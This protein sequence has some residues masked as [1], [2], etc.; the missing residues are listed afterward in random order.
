MANHMIEVGN[1]VRKY[2]EVVAVDGIT[3][4]V[5]EGGF[6]GFLGPNGAG[7]TTTMR[8]LATLLRKTSGE[9][10]IA[11]F[12]VD[13]QP[14]EVRK[15]IGFAMQDVSLECLLEQLTQIGRTQSTVHPVKHG[16]H[17]ALDRSQAIAKFMR[18]VAYGLIANTDPT[19]EALLLV[20]TAQRFLAQSDRGQQA[21]N[22]HRNRQRVE[23]KPDVRKEDD[24]D[25]H[26]PAGEDHT[27][28]GAEDESELRAER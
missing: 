4:Q 9:V 23:G 19:S 21:K 5:G 28:A 20:F 22:D 3:F 6:F 13:A 26:C 7:K 8:I 11:G 16:L 12:D 10:R 25:H 14:D 15:V 2:D 17:S 18:H 1:L 27:N 24:I